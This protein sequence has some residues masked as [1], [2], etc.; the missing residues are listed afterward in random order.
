M[1]FLVNRAVEWG[2]YPDCVWPLAVSTDW[3][4]RLWHGCWICNR[5]Q[6][7]PRKPIIDLNCPLP[8]VVKSHPWQTYLMA[9]PYFWCCENWLTQSCYSSSPWHCPSA[10]WLSA[11]SWKPQPALLGSA[12]HVLSGSRQLFQRCLQAVNTYML[13]I[14]IFMP[15]WF[16]L[17]PATIVSYLH[18]LSTPWTLALAFRLSLCLAS[19]LYSVFGVWHQMNVNR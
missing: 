2:L 12:P 3:E 18:L 11:L 13:L 9:L 4:L 19:L 14:T 1:Y 7:N 10:F 16:L 15:H 8:V 5:G 17:I 6:A